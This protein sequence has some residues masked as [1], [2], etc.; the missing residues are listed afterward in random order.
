MKLLQ[1]ECVH[2][3]ILLARYIIRDEVS[4]LEFAMCANCWRKISHF[5]GYTFVELSYRDIL[6]SSDKFTVSKDIPF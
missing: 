6:L 1:R 2:K 5:K 3:E 4:K